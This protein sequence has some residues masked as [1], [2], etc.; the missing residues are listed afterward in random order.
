MDWKKIW[1]ALK[2]P[3]GTTKTHKDNKDRKFI[4]VEWYEHRANEIAGEAYRKE[5]REYQVDRHQG[6]VKTVVRVY[7]GESFRDGYGFKEIDENGITNAV[8]LAFSESVRNA[9]DGYEMGWEDLNI[10]VRKGIK[11]GEDEEVFCKKCSLVLSKEDRE[12]IKRYPLLKFDFHPN[13]VPE[14]LKKI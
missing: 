6:F 1:H 13:C 8:D 10:Y 11:V 9:F 2:E 5:I 4:P 7:I 14:H 3:F 12:F